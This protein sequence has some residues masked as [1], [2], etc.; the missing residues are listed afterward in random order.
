[1]GVS[2]LAKKS[3]SKEEGK[4][5]KKQEHEVQGAPE[6]QTITM[7]AEEQ[8][9]MSEAVKQVLQA[10]EDLLKQQEELQQQ[11]LR[12]QA[13]FEN[14]RRR[15]RQERESLLNQGA[16]DS[17]KSLLPVIDNFERALTTAQEG[18]SY[19]AGVQMIYRQLMQILQDAGLKQIEALETPFDPQ[20]HEAIGNV[21][22]T[23][24]KKGLVV[25]EVQKGYL[26]KD[27]LLRPSIVQVG[28]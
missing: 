25:T 1:M 17:I 27:K 3:S 28:V 2:R 7:T 8:K 15:S 12:L 26:F 10:N 13:D 22:V 20:I 19:A 11:H 21:E 9:A 18:D 24:D 23:E 16:A 5:K 6:Q 4:E 14:F